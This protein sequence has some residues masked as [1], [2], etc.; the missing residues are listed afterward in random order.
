MFGFVQDIRCFSFS[1]L[2][3]DCSKYNKMDLGVDCYLIY[4]M[5]GVV[6]S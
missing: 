6:F 4:A 3:L 5:R 2:F 1:F